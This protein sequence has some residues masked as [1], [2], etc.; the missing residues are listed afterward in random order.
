MERDFKQ[1]IFCISINVI[2]ILGFLLEHDY[3]R[4]GLR[5]WIG[6]HIHKE[7][8]QIITHPYRN[9]NAVLAKAPLKSGYGWVI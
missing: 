2:N 4:I 9:F 7:K 5:A 3:T 1:T 6:D 8:S